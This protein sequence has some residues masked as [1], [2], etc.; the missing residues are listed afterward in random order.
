MPLAIADTAR[1]F[2]RRQLLATAGAGTALAF[3][4]TGTPAWATPAPPR[5]ALA[6]QWEAAT[7][8]AAIP[9]PSPEVHALNRLT[10][11]IRPEDLAHVKKVGVR[12]FIREQLQPDDLDDSAVEGV[13]AGAFPS[14]TLAPPQI[15]PVARDKDARRPVA[16]D[17]KQAT[18]YRAVA[19]SRQLFE[20]LVDFWTNHFNVYHFDSLCAALKTADDRDVVRPNVLGDF[21]TFLRASAASPAMLI[22]L[23][24][25]QNK[26]Q[27]PNE[28]Y[29]RE[30]ME[31]HTISVNGGYTQTDVQEIA[32]CFTG[33]TLDQ[34][35]AFQFL[36]RNHDTGA[37]TVL[38]VA[39][40][41][42]RGIQDGE[43]VLAILAAHP[44]TAT[45][46]ATKLCR[47]LISDQPPAGAVSAAAATFSATG[48]DLRETTRT[49][50]LSPEFTA[51]A[52]AK[53]KRP[54]EFVAAAVRAVGATVS[55]PT[56]TKSLY[57]SLHTLGQ[58]P[59]D[60]QAPNGYPDATGAW[61]NTNGLLARWNF[62]VSLVNGTLAGVKVDL[63]HLTP[64]TP[65]S[66][67]PAQL[68]DALTDR[69]LHRPLTAADRSQLLAY[70]S[71]G[72][73]ANRP[74]GQAAALAK[75]ADVAALLLDSPYFQL[76]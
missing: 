7:N 75:T 36:A 9:P 3:L 35:G 18:I 60:W 34:G 55:T 6:T 5:P 56:G 44:A 15:G 68:V 38:G 66:L 10:F 48:G 63:A 11:G 57:T 69:I 71:A 59:F 28:N 2:T 58:S 46:L 17:L 12:G 54:F 73:P 70:A 33:W 8:P 76:R 13:L 24:N 50:L 25:A 27:G 29:A 23:N 53:A 52:D 41:A 47:R 51:S 43:Q 19:S 49:I 26:K 30:V 14:L 32:R 64:G 42:G 65:G 4:D 22:M 1:G 40:P 39:I 62:V 61:I 20:L 72:V 16:L 37:K 31:L 21:G 45:F 67:T 74:I